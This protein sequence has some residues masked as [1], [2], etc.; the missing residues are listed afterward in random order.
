VAAQY[1]YVLNQVL[2]LQE[3]PPQLVGYYTFLMNN[4]A[5]IYFV[6]GIVTLLFSL[7]CLVA[8]SCGSRSLFQLNV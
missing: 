8:G 4:E 2:Q 5:A 7:Y 6:A 3:V 1:L